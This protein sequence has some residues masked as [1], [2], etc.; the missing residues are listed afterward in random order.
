MMNQDTS[1]LLCG[2]EHQVGS[3]PAT[4]FRGIHLGSRTLILGLGGLR[5]PASRG[6]RH[7]R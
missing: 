7:M 1:H 6:I 5:N 4:G 3:K 2:H